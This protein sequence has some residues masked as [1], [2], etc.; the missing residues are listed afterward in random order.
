MTTTDT[1]TPTTSGAAEDR[2]LDETPARR[3]PARAGPRRRRDRR[4][5][6]HRARHRPVRDPRDPAPGDAASRS[7]TRP[8]STSA[9]CASGSAAWSCAEIVEYDPA[10]RHLRPAA[11]EVRPFVTGPGADNLA[12]TMRLRRRSWAR[13]TPKIIE[14]FRQRRRADLR[15]LPGVPRRAG[16]RQRGGQRRRP[17]R[18]DHPAHRSRRTGSSDGID[19]AR[20]RLRRGPRGEPAR[21][22]PSRAAASPASTSAPRRSAAARAEADTVGPDA[23]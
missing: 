21:T 14:C 22:A 12:R 20:R 15:R 16:R 17:G 18:H 5:G 9:T 11:R 1:A 13:S 2:S 4:P 23:T 7:P 8:G 3:R 6:E 10:A 19:V